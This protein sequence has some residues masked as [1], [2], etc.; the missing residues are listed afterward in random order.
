MCSASVGY[1]NPTNSAPVFIA[2][3]PL[4]SPCPPVEHFFALFCSVGS[5]AFFLLSLSLSSLIRLSFSLTFGGHKLKHPTVPRGQY[6]GTRPICRS[7]MSLCNHSMHHGQLQLASA[8]A[9]ACVSLAAPTLFQLTIKICL[10][11]T[12]NQE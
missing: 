5:L 3:S 1:G 4:L 7:I 11:I 10:E 12:I 2:W 6:Q 8:S 9:Y